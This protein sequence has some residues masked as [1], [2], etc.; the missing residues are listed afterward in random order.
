MR[1]TLEQDVGLISLGRKIKG[2]SEIRPDHA[3]VVFSGAA[4]LSYSDLNRIIDQFRADLRGAGFG[5]S[6]RIAVALANGPSAALAIVAVSSSAVAVPINPKQTLPEIAACFDVLSPD[7]VLLLQGADSAARRVAERRGLTIIE[8]IP[9]S[10]NTLGLR[11]DPPRIGAPAPFDDPEPD[12]PAFILQSSGTSA[13][14]KSIPFSHRNMLAAAARLEAWFELTPEDRCLSVSPP[15]YSHGLKVTVFTPLLTGGTAV[16]PTNPSRF[17][18]SEWFGALKPTWYSAGPTLHRLILDVAKSSPDAKSS[19]GLRFALSGGAPLPREVHEGL[20]VALGVPVVEHY[21]SSE[22][23]Q[24]AT[25]RPSPGASKPGTCGIPWPGT[26]K[27]VDGEG[28]PLPSGRQG[29]VLVRGPTLMSGYLDAPDLNR[30]VFV[31]GWFKTGDIGSLD[32]DGFLTL[33]GRL[34]EMINRGGEKVW[35]IEIDEALARHPAV[36][37]AAAFG[38]PHPRLGEDV[39]AAVVLRPGA[40]VGALEL[41]NYLSE[42]LAEF[43]IPRRIAFVDQ[44]PKGPTGKILRRKLAGFLSTTAAPA[45]EVAQLRG[46]DQ[47]TDQLLQIWRR[48]LN[49][50]SLTID[51]DFFESGGDSL[52]ALEMLFEVE[53]SMGRAAPSTVLFEATTV[54]LLSRRLSEAGESRP[55]PVVQLSST[56]S[57]SPLIYFHGNPSGGGY[58]AKFARLLGS[59]QPIFVVSPHGL[60]SGPVPDTIEEM[61]AD[62]LPAIL[63]AQPRG[64]YR[65]GGYCVGGIVAF[66]AARLLVASGREVELVAMIDPPTINAIPSVQRL[67]SASRWLGGS[68]RRVTERACA[69]LWYYL[70]LLE[71]ISVMSPS[72]R[73]ELSAAKARRLVGAS[74]SASGRLFRRDPPEISEPASEHTPLGYM[75]FDDFI[76]RYSVAMSRYKPAPLPTRVVFF[77]AEFAGTAWRRLCSELEL[78][79]LSGDHYTVTKD[80]SE[81]ADHFA[82][83]LEQK[84][85]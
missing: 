61:A 32:E 24:I 47:L 15:Y 29:E 31:D 65:L 20:Q 85:A 34:K 27:L 12:A 56:G 81:V 6:A 63:E 18:I 79:K 84:A 14:P 75:P 53:R 83:K 51:D 72:R 45:A 13:E 55:K 62:R 49:S 2:I 76:R 64:P 19:H 8:A 68:G 70:T 82:S 21:G 60:D 71:R 30:A 35:P 66:E 22:A 77:S 78:I 46:N 4:P 1:S 7:A 26:V 37:E 5:R 58:V 33:H 50:T 41:R 67:L 74:V 36:A 40:S 80:P 48:L 3:A 57:R 59:D 73:W 16:F 9:A 52:L 28:K 54:R 10:G 39:A 38:I 23:A 69:G 25:N 44:M 17:E 11:I 42:R 43:K